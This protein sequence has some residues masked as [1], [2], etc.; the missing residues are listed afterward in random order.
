MVFYCTYSHQARSICGRR[1]K[2]EAKQRRELTMR[3]YN[4]MRQKAVPLHVARYIAGWVFFSSFCLFVS[5]FSCFCCFFFLLWIHF[6]SHILFFHAFRGIVL[7]IFFFWRVVSDDCI[8]TNRIISSVVESMIARNC[9]VFIS[10]IFNDCLKYALHRKTRSQA[11]HFSMMNVRAIVLRFLL[12]TMVKMYSN[13]W[14]SARWQAK[15]FTPYHFKWRSAIRSTNYTI[16][17]IRYSIRIQI[18][19]SF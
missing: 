10:L 6:L 7:F 5:S 3:M 11:R 17:A 8:Q 13:F 9:A 15:P 14:L 1:T 2:C 19:V 12:P 16:V 4:I 18:V